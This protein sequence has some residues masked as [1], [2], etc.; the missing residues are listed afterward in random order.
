MILKKKKLL[1]KD[2]I[3]RALDK[4]EISVSKARE[5]QTHRFLVLR[6]ILKRRVEA[7]NS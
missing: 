5:Q 4:R 3:G 6:T 1:S 7:T 2:Y